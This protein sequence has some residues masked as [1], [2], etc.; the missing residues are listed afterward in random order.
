MTLPS[1][2]YADTY[3]RAPGFITRPS[4]RN[5]RSGSGVWWTTPLQTAKSKVADSNGR[6]SSE[7]QANAIDGRP[8]ADTDRRATSRLRWLRSIAET[9]PPA[10]TIARALMAVPPQPASRQRRPA[11]VASVRLAR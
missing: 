9:R 3:T 4:S 1:K 2:Q 5:A 10:A 8:A 11:Q 6:S 7:P